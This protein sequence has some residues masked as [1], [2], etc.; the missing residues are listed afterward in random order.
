MYA[1]MCMKMVLLDSMEFHVFTIL[2]GK[3]TYAEM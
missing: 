1:H 2:R 3:K